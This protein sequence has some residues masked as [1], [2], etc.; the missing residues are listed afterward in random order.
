MSTENTVEA[1]QLLSPKD[2]TLVTE[3]RPA[4]AQALYLRKRVQRGTISRTKTG[5]L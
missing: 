5:P 4:G 3:R 2:L 1:P